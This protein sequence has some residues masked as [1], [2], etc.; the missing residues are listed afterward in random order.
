MDVQLFSIAEHPPEGFEAAGK[1]GENLSAGS[2]ILFAKTVGSALEFLSN[3][4]SECSGVI[5]TSGSSFN[6]S[7]VS[8][9]FWHLTI[10]NSNLS[11]AKDIAECFLNIFGQANI[12]QA[13]SYESLQNRISELLLE[14]VKSRRSEENLRKHDTELQQID[15]LAHI[16]SWKWNL[17][18]GVVVLSPELCRIYS[19]SENKEYFDINAFIDGYTHPDDIQDVK[20]TVESA[21]TGKPSK[22]L[23]FRIIRPNGEIRWI[24]AS[25]PQT[26]SYDEENS[27]VEII[28]IQQDITERIKAED[29]LHQSE[30]KLGEAAKNIPGAIF[31]FYIRKSGE[32]GIDF[33]SGNLEKAL[34][35]R[36]NSDNHFES[37]VAGIPT[38]AYKDD[39]YSS[40]DKAVKAIEDWNFETLFQK[41]SG[42]II[43]IRGLSKP[44]LLKDVLLFNG[45]M[46]DVTEEK[47]ATQRIEHLNSLLLAIRNVNQ[48]IVQ[49]TELDDLLQKACD[50]LIET[51]SYQDCTVVL[52]DESG[53]IENVFQAGENSYQRDDLI[54]GKLPLC[55]QRTLETGN[56]IV[57][58]N[59]DE[60]SGCS[61]L[62]KHGTAFL[63]TFV[64]P[65]IS[66]NS[67]VGIL[68]VALSSDA[69][70]DSEECILLEEVTE[71]IAFA[72]RK[73]TAESELIQSE[74]RYR[75]LFDSSHDAIMTLG[76]PSWKFTSGNPSILEMFGVAS[77]M[78]F[79]AIGP[80]DVSPEFQ[81]DGQASTVKA[82]QMIDTAMKEGSN[83]FEWTH[84]KV[85]GESFPATVLLTRV[86]M[87]EK[88]F[89]QATVR[90]ITE[91]KELEEALRHSEALI[92]D[93][94]DSVPGVIFQ[95]Y[96]R[97]DGKMGLYFVSGR[98]TEVLGIS[99]EPEG[100]F[101]RAVDRIPLEDHRAFMTSI[102]E[103]IST[104]SDWEYST[105]FIKPSGEQVRIKGMAIPTRHE[106]EII[107]N[108]VFLDITDQ[109]EAE[110]ALV[111]ERDYTTSIIRGTPAIICGISP[112]GITRYLNPAAEKATGYKSNEIVGRNWWKI[113][114]PGEDYRQVEELFKKLNEQDDVKDYEMTLTA[115]NGDRRIISWNSINRFDDNN[116][117]AEIIG[118]GFDVT[119]RKRTEADLLE[120]EQL[121]R[122][123]VENAP[124]GIFLID[125]NYKVIYS[126]EQL[127][128]MSGYSIDELMGL[129]FREVLDDTSRDTVIDRYKRRQAGKEIENQYEIGVILPDV[130]TPIRTLGMES[131][132]L[133]I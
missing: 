121:F 79:T 19:I 57:M 125:S 54:S 85:S 106:D 104:A 39:F 118:F 92:R 102:N 75:K 10:P 1:N 51:R 24:T 53:D 16:G 34:G 105:A 80:W 110:R 52:L 17:K 43:W 15:S 100:F 45:V 5:V 83:F 60:C 22:P 76:P 86:T 132:I 14:T 47:Y 107:F 42:E 88:T 81:P 91:Q 65:M 94:A 127:S 27:P 33:V 9:R 112:E 74:K 73:L 109:W 61:F 97:P 69:I 131:I 101:E 29:D 26:V 59:A 115:R 63:P 84:C 113:F 66:G 119:E 3:V 55:I 108:G 95:F 98:A 32:Y 46:L 20:E 41:P 23:T 123:V 89:L 56:Y 49:E 36:E 122:S 117:I 116:S 30:L 120:S 50:S 8:A 64:A 7:P 129:D 37:F 99:P 4:S 25:L 114:Y 128:L 130:L 11:E 44:T 6:S 77:E 62:G 48:L 133:A 90:D 31:Q 103:A 13:D 35:I 71:D 124:A 78:E 12:E 18:T 28:G 2:I 70:I 126:N 40:I 111:A 58:K 67:T 68:F 72:M 38:R 93:V 96:T 82:K 21:S 87:Q